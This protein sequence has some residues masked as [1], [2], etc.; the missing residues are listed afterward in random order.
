MLKTNITKYLGLG[1]GVPIPLVRYVHWRAST[2]WMAQGLP[3][4]E[5]VETVVDV[6]SVTGGPLSAQTQVAPSGHSASA[7]R[8]A[9]VATSTQ[10]SPAH[11]SWAQ[12]LFGLRGCRETVT[13]HQ[14]AGS[15]PHQKSLYVLII[16][17]CP[18]R[19]HR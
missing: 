3:S 1:S 6:V 11:W 19:K 10:S 17:N 16:H 2:H 9:P 8:P 12:L 18:P 4:A 14:S 5:V 7:S 13:C 15:P